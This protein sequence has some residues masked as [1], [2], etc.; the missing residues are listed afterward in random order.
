MG[1]YYEIVFKRWS[2]YRLPM[3][4]RRI[5][6]SSD[7]AE[8]RVVARR[9]ARDRNTKQRISPGQTGS[10]IIIEHDTETPDKP[11]IIL[12][13]TVHPYKRPTHHS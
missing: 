2:K 9:A 10:I 5:G 1:L 4:P 6:G 3:K 8:A 13:H 7:L 11:T 12:E